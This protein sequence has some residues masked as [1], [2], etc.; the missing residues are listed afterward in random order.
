MI[1]QSYRPRTAFTLVEIM[2]VVAIIAVLT[3]IAIPSFMKYRRDAEISLIASEMRGLRDG[4]QIYATKY[5]TYPPNGEGPGESPPFPI[6]K[7][8]NME[9]WTNSR[10]FGGTY[11]WIGQA[12]P[13]QPVWSGWP[14]SAFNVRGY[15]A[16]RD[17][18]L[19]V[20]KILDDGNLGSGRFREVSYSGGRRLIYR[21]D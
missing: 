2:I 15:S 3:A 8:I 21:L 19:Q 20:D 7:Y 1:P 6:D 9:T 16:D 18:L 13:G 17:D 12:P 4:F 5:G 14:Y 10:P 11:F